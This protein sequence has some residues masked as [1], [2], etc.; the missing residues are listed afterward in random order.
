MFIAGQ[1]GWNE[2]EEMASGF[3]AQFAQAL[4]NVLAVVRAAAARSRSPVRRDEGSACFDLE[5]AG[6]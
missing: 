1:V 2:R 3:A 6:T 5:A 4:D